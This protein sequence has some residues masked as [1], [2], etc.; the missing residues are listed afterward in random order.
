METGP[1]GGCSN[2]GGAVTAEGG[3]GVWVQELRTGGVR[4]TCASV[5]LQGSRHPQGLAWASAHTRAVQLFKSSVCT[6]EARAQLLTREAEFGRKC[7]VKGKSPDF[8]V[9]GAWT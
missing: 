6:V 2:N 4:R 5:M 1:Q 8:G 7:V 9:R 3:R